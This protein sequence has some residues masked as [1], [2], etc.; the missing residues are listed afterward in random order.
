[1]QSDK[2]WQVQCT[3]GYLARVGE[4][5]RMGGSSSKNDF[6]N[7]I[8]TGSMGPP[9]GGELEIDADMEMLDLRLKKLTSVRSFPFLDAWQNH[10]CWECLLL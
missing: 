3:G 8:G 10:F 6:S 2:V 5:S 9:D 4:G 1:M 7:K